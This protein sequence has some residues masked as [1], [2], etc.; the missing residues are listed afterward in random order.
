MCARSSQGGQ[1]QQEQQQLKLR[2]ESK[3]GVDLVTEVDKVRSATQL[4]TRSNRCLALIFDDQ[5]SNIS[6]TPAAS[7]HASIFHPPFQRANQSS[8]LCEET[9][10][11]SLR[12]EY[13]GHRFVGE[14]STFAGTQDA[15]HDPATP[16]WYIDPV[17]GTTNF[18]HGAYDD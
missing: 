8:Q 14:E 11:A 7:M 12:K 16:T 17:D 1:Q 6:T 2:V 9:I 4:P 13:P 10:I 18:V 15:T 3:G 5:P